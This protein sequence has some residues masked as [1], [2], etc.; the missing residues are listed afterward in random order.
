MAQADLG[1]NY[2]ANLGLEGAVGTDPRVLIVNIVK[3]FLSLLGIIAVAI[4][5]YA[6]WLWMTSNG[7]PEKIN[8]AK[9]ALTGA[10][11]GL[12]I[13]LSAFMIVVF[14]S[15]FVSDA[16]SPPCNAVCASGEKC[17]QGSPD[18]C[19]ANAEICCNRGG[20]NECCAAGGYCCAGIGCSITPCSTLIPSVFQLSST[21]PMDGSTN[22]IKNVRLRFNFNL[23]IDPLTVDA[24]SV[25]ISDSVGPVSGDLSVSG[26]RIIF[27]P[28]AGTCP[29]NPCNADRCFA[30]GTHVTVLIH[31]LVSSS[32][33]PLEQ[34]IN[35]ATSLAENCGTTGN[36]CTVSFDVG[37]LIDCEDPNVGLNITQVCQAANNPIDAWAQDDSGVADIELLVDSNPYDINVNGAAA[38]PFFTTFNWDGSGY[39]PGTPVTFTARANDYDAHT[40]SRSITTILRPEHC[41][42]GWLN[43]D[44]TGVDCGGTECASC[45]GAACGASLNDD[46]DIDENGT[47]D[48]DCT[49]NN[50]RCSSNFCDCD[51]SGADCQIVGYAAGIDDCC[52]CQRPP[53][54]DWVT[55]LGGFCRDAADNPTNNPCQRDTDCVVGYCDMDTGNGAVG[56]LITIIGRNFG[57]AAGIVEI[58]GVP[59]THIIPGCP[60]TWAN[61]QVIVQVPPGV[62]LPI[63]N[64]IVRLEAAN[65]YE[66]TTGF[67]ARGPVLDFLINSIVRPGLCGITPD[68]ASLGATIDYVGINLGGSSAFFGNISSNIA[69]IDMGPFGATTGQAGVPNLQ[70]GQT[71]TFNL[72]GIINSNYLTFTKIAETPPGP[73]IT[74]FDP[75]NGAPGQYVT[76]SGTGFGASQGSSQVFFGTD[77]ADYNFPAICA[78]SIWGDNQV[79]VKVPSIGA[80]PYVISMDLGVSIIDTSALT[81]SQFTVNTTV[82]PNLCKIQPVMGPNNSNISLWGED[83]GAPPPAGLVRFHSGVDQTIVTLWGVEADAMRI[84]TTISGAAISGPVKVVQGGVEGN[85]LDLT[86]GLCSAA[87]NPDAA[88]GTWFCCPEN[89]YREGRCVADPADPVNGCDLA[90]SSSVYEWDFSTED[91]TYAG[92]HDPCQEP[93]SMV[94][95][96]ITLPICDPNQDLFCDE[97]QSCICE[98][99]SNTD[100]SCQARSLRLGSCEPYFCPNSPGECSPY[101]GQ[102][103]VVDTCDQ[104]CNGVAN[105]ATAGCTYYAD[106]DQCV[107]DSLVCTKTVQDVFNNN[108]IARCQDSSSEMRWHFATPGSC[109]LGWTMTTNNRCQEDGAGGLCSLCPS[110]FSCQDH[111]NDG[112]GSCL[113]DEQLCPGAPACNAANECI[114]IDNGTCECCCEIGQDARDCCW[115]LTCEGECGD[116]RITDT[117]TYGYCSGC[118]NTP[119]PDAACNC[120]GHSGKFCDLSVP[121]GVCRDCAGLGT[122]DCQAH[123]NVCCL[124]AMAGDQC[125]GGDGNLLANGVCAYFNCDTVQPWLCASTTPITTGTYS[126]VNTCSSDC[127]ATYGNNGGESCYNPTLGNCSLPCSSGYSCLGI[128]GCSAAGCSAYDSTCRCCCTPGAGDNCNLINPQLVCEPDLSP[129]S[130]TARGLC[131]GCSIDTDCGLPAISA[132]CGQDSC[133]R[134][135]PDIVSTMPADDDDLVCRNAAVIANFSQPIDTG[136]LT[137]NV[138]VVGEYDEPCPVGTQ[139]LAAADF[140]PISQNIVIRYINNA[141]LGFKNLIAK[142]WLNDTAYAYVNP[143]TNMNYCAITGGATGYNDPV[144]NGVMEFRSNRL[145]DGNRR[146]YVIV[147]GDSSLD[148]SSGV[149]NQWG[150]GLNSSDNPWQSPSTGNNIFNGIDY[151]NAYVWTFTTMDDQGPGQGVCEIGQVLV[152]PSSYLFQTTTE[153]ANETD[154]V[155]TDPSFD[156]RAD[157]D[158]VFVAQA[159]SQ[160]NQVLTPVPGYAWDWVWSSDL[161]AVADITNETGWP[162]GER[163]QLVEADSGAS[164]ANTYIRA[165]INLTD[166]TYSTVG[167]GVVGAARVYV[168]LCSNPWPPVVAGTWSPWIDNSGNCTIGAGSCYDTHFELYY[169]RDEGQ[170]GSYD[171]LPSLVSG[172]EQIIRSQEGEIL[173]EAFF[174]RASSPVGTTTLN[175]SNTGIGRTVDVSWPHITI[176]PLI[177]GYRLYWGSSPGNYS[178][179]VTI[180]NDGSDNHENVGPCAGANNFACAV[181]SLNNNQTYYFSLTSF[182]QSGV[183]SGHF[184]EVLVD[185]ADTL[186]P[187]TPIL[188]PITVGNSELTLSWSPIPDADSYIVSYG[189]SSGAPYGWSQN[190]G[191]DTSVI[192]SGLTSGTTYY[193][194]VR[195]SDNYGNESPDSNEENAVPN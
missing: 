50:S 54:I 111:D 43:F 128:S 72:N 103:I 6:G 170:F 169:C 140:E 15:R 188:L 83:F 120:E 164:D 35:P 150:I 157:K 9:K 190:I 99:N 86:I 130:G 41:C 90:L 30:T 75:D 115:P 33:R 191:S 89:T 149:L 18:Y 116:D 104:T 186:A 144:G 12:I 74:G 102:D 92:W 7:D 112:D 91:V 36:P 49:L 178:D 32:G 133:C 106:R 126:S 65:G 21:V 78:D 108:V 121:N 124:D 17:C 183:E 55:P 28:D 113:S 79:I 77:E 195:S 10:I 156:T 47:P 180:Y 3:Y 131:C 127:A 173:K 37:D 154:N 42:D 81:P 59:A 184:G 182:Y 174:P 159:R 13:I 2:A 160:N 158:K 73:S 8:K 165:E 25:E 117:D 26:K 27:E 14:I 122:A 151:I 62:S 153:N 139:F 110:G 168:F 148:S 40:S 94:C 60:N 187:P 166:S 114:E 58:D 95:T 93:L 176:D 100:D 68:T 80:G 145:L 24:S 22:V 31:D 147:K 64:V 193:F 167:D 162:A 38:N 84:D 143:Q 85:G 57:S 96:D 5:M 4:V 152:R 44:E 177:I 45:D 53:T 82:R 67:D 192:I 63:T 179:F 70:N 97:T 69:A 52:L 16:I 125:R 48:I 129:C 123:S 76:I 155:P 105:C 161:P 61:N 134:A 109:P 141:W 135:R 118:A 56:N 137:G 119:D 171:D 175:V 101:A 87:P 189:I 146:Y 98:F 88:C 71:S 19:C 51:M 142:I 163:R 11:I 132:G 172:N 185:V 181:T 23:N 136:S 39:T 107:L 1:I 20:V 138:L 34:W 46:C 29:A 194:V 66:D